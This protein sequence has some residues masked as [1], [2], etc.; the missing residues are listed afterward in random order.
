MPPIVD[1]TDTS[2]TNIHT[3][4]VEKQRPQNHLQAD[5][6]SAR[7]SRPRAR[8]PANPLVAL[9]ALLAKRRVGRPQKRPGRR[10]NPRR[11]QE[12]RLNQ[13][14]RS[15]LPS[16]TKVRGCPR[17][18]YH[19]QL[20]TFACAV[21]AAKEAQRQLIRQIVPPAED[22]PFVRVANLVENILQYKFE[23]LMKSGGD[24]LEL[25]E[26]G[27]CLHGCRA[28]KPKALSKTT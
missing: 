25:Q 12:S 21:A 23:E 17:C 11:K 14:Q 24:A 20:L 28:C 6:S 19:K 13:L 15:A 3:R 10:K 1:I 16:K 8:S 27:A 4:F 5:L 7:W 26:A 2:H 18:V 22:S 9:S